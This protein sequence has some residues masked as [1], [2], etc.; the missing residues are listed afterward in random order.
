MNKEMI[1]ALIEVSYYTEYTE[2]AIC[3]VADI[4]MIVEN[5]RELEERGGFNTWIEQNW[6]ENDFLEWLE[7]NKLEDLYK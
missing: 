5:S 2:S 4:P 7:D 6:L 1:K 3:G